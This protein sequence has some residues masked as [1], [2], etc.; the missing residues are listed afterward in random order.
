MFII[1]WPHFQLIYL[2]FCLKKYISFSR[3]QT[4]NRT[5][6]CINCQKIQVHAARHRQITSEHGRTLAGSTPSENQKVVHR[7]S[8]TRKLINSN[9][10]SLVL[11]NFN[12]NVWFTY[13]S[14]SELQVKI[15]M[16]RLSLLLSIPAR[17]LY[18]RGRSVRDL[19]YSVK[20]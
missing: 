2:C 7:N 11:Q 5:C 13:T 18:Q 6:E 20:W 9:R 17:H 3:L 16:D 15:V 12:T 8:E 10:T 14:H 4:H 19:P 1:S